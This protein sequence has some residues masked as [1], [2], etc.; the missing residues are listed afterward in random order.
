LARLEKGSV[1]SRASTVNAVQR[2]LT[3]GGVE[4]F[5]PNTKGEGARLKSPRS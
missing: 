4:F 2:A 1:D 3:K 5:E